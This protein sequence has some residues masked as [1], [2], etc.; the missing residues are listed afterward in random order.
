M[1]KCSS[2]NLHNYANDTLTDERLT[3]TSFALSFIREISQII[4]SQQLFSEILTIQRREPNKSSW[5]LG[6]SWRRFQESPSFQLD[7]SPGISEKDKMRISKR[8]KVH[9]TP[10]NSQL[11]TQSRTANWTLTRQSGQYLERR[12][13]L[14]RCPS[15]LSNSKAAGVSSTRRRRRPWLS[16]QR[17]CS[18][19]WSR[20]DSAAHRQQSQRRSATPPSSCSYRSWRVPHTWLAWVTWPVTRMS[21]ASQSYALRSIALLSVQV[22]PQCQTLRTTQ[23]IDSSMINTG[24]CVKRSKLYS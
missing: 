10:L 18:R 20:T 2:S 19:R 7:L 5:K 16:R 15:A 3:E 4:L 24:Y 21:S 1:L 23:T 8:N 22:K 13:L 12:N 9:N 6:D 11:T 14:P 17:E